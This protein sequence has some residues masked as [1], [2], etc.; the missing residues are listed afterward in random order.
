MRDQSDLEQLRHELPLSAS[1]ARLRRQSY[2]VPRTLRQDLCIRDDVLAGLSEQ[3]WHTEIQTPHRRFSR[4][5]LSDGCVSSAHA[6]AS[7]RARS[8]HANS[9]CHPADLS[10]RSARGALD[11]FLGRPMGRSIN[12]CDQSDQFRY[13]VL[14]ICAVFRDVRAYSGSVVRGSAAEGYADGRR[15]ANSADGDE[16]PCQRCLGHRNRLAAPVVVLMAKAGKAMLGRGS[17]RISGV[18]ATHG[19]RRAHFVFKQA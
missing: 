9:V 16:R 7:Q 18:G 8:H 12:V 13:P 17:S 2:S 10:I 14:A 4:R 19:T 5:L 11:R 6:D 3:T 15:L 1:I